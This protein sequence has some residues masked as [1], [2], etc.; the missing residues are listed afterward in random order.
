MPLPAAHPAPSALPS[1]TPAPPANKQ[2]VTCAASALCLQVVQ[3]EPLSDKAALLVEL[4][5]QSLASG[6]AR[7]A[8]SAVSALSAT[9]SGGWQRLAAVLGLPTG[10]SIVRIPFLNLAPAD[11]LAPLQIAMQPQGPA[12]S[13]G[14]AGRV[15]AALARAEAAAATQL[16]QAPRATG[17]R[18]HANFLA[19]LDT[20]Q[21][22]DS[23]LLADLET[24]FIAAYK[25]RRVWPFAA[26][27]PLLPMPAS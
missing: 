3:E 8:A 15:T 1:R 14:V 4:Q 21:Q 27:A 13:P 9:Y 20:V 12:A 17:E 16:Q 23:H 26:A 11:C 10:P 7:A 19:V 18:L 24:G 5:V 6:H 25:V 22:H 2:P